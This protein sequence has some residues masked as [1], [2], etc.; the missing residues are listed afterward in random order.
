VNRNPPRIQNRRALTLLEVVAATALIAMLAVVTVPLFAKARAALEPLDRAVEVFDL[1]RLADDVFAT[2]LRFGVQR[3]WRDLLGTSTMFAW[4]E[5]DRPPV[6][7]R[8]DAAGEYARVV[9]ECDG[10]VV[11]RFIHLDRPENGAR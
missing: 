11:S 5:A 7:V 4:S 6:R 9:F 3:N 10:L 8:V 2:P 1:A